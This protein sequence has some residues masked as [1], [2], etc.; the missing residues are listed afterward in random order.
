MTQYEYKILARNRI[1]RYPALFDRRRSI[2]LIVL[3]IAIS[4]VPV[5]LYRFGRAFY[6]EYQI[7]GFLE[8]AYNAQRPGGGRLFGTPYSPQ[9]DAPH[10]QSQLGRAQILLL[11]HKNWITRPKLQQM[12]QLAAGEWQAFTESVNSLPLEQ[13]ESSWT[14]NNLGASFLALAEMDPTYLLKAL[15]QFERAVELAPKAP[16]PRYNL[17]I[18]YRKLRL[19]RLADEMLQRYAELDSSSMW[20]RELNESSEND[21]STALNDLRRAVETDDVREAERLFDKNPE[22]CRRL[23]MQYGLASIEESPALVRFIAARIE[24][25]FGDKTISAMLAPLFT[26]RGEATIVVR[27]LVT[28][29]AK[30][31][32]RENVRA[33]LQAYSQ[34]DKLVGRTDSLFDRLWI[35][36]NRVDSQVRAGEFDSARES[37][38][39]IIS[40]ARK[41][42]FQWL[43]A[44]ALSIYGSTTKLT[45]SRAELMSLLAEA[46]RIFTAVG[47][48]YDRVRPL[49]YLAAFR[50]GAGDQDEALKLALECLRLTD[51]SDKVRM[52]SL[53]WLIAAVLYRKGMP[54]R[55]VLFEKES[56]EQSQKTGNPGLEA[57]AAFSLAQLYESLSE[58]VRAEQYLQVAREALDRAP[59]GPERV[60]DEMVLGMVEAR[61]Y[62][63]RRRYRE[64]ESLLERNL[65][66]YAQQPF[67]ATYVRS[68]SL[69]LLAKAYA[70]LGRIGDASRKFNEAI[71]IVEN[72]DQY[73]QSEKLRVKF[74]D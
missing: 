21:E 23:A 27:K 46:E 48:S 71:E 74:D 4:S 64:V 8:G 49:Y 54:S 73:L 66:L 15:D 42:Q 63:N 17:V 38:R 30:L 39:R 3:L 56:V 2:G 32:V 43:V 51:D 65:S 69:M 11:Q 26:D 13:G 14:L 25:R 72:D 31:Y 10:Y 40:F 1:S 29:G 6:F 59:A 68:Q 5:A 22:L 33:S 18:T 57:A 45:T 37:L 70:E 19:P 55:A 9:S 34:A 67:Q 60:R 53:D 44:K 50:R 7:R 35:D 58:P 16:E 61:I 12:L 20:Y 47:A 36:I 28:E 24:Y 62:L 52:A 41:Q